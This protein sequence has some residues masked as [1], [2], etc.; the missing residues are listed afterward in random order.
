MSVGHN[1]RR[2]RP[3]STMTTQTSR[4]DRIANTARAAGRRSITMVSGFR[5]RLVLATLVAVAA[6]GVAAGLAFA[7]GSAPAIGTG[8][9]VVD[10]KLAYQGGAAAGTGIVLTSSGEVLT[11]NH[12]IQGATSVDVVVPGTS[13]HY[14]ARVVGY[15]Q[16]A[17]VA[18]LQLSGASNLKTAALGDSSKLTTGQAVHAV[19]NAGGTGTLTPAG[20]TITGLGKAIT[21]GDTQGASKRLTGLIETNAALQPGDS[22][23]PLLTANGR[24]IGMDTAAST[25]FGFQ[26]ASVT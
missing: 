2:R 8:V 14:S 7:R 9:V 22:G 13:H 21:V 10:T 18:V 25:G 24:V 17:D 1:F 26:A 4:R 23:G 3:R 11:N 6:L 19:G 16:T 20:G 12:V 15:D 5:A